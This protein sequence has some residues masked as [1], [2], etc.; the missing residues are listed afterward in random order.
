[1]REFKVPDGSRDSVEK[2]LEDVKACTAHG[3]EYDGRG[4][5]RDG[6]NKAQT[7][8]MVNEYRSSVDEGHVGQSP[9][10]CLSGRMNP[11]VT[12]LQRLKQGSPDE[13]SAWAIACC[14]LVQQFGVHIP[15]T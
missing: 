2:V 13:D 1:M 5:P 12:P 3:V 10:Y 4:A 6:H 14:G 15:A 11:V 7:T 9:V 8:Y